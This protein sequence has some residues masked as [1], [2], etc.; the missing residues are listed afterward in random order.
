[1]GFTNVSWPFEVK[2]SGTYWKM[3]QN[4]SKS[5]LTKRNSSENI[6]KML[7]NR[8]LKRIS[9]NSYKNLQKRMKK[10]EKKGKKCF[11]LPCRHPNFRAMPNSEIRVGVFWR[12][13]FFT[14][15]DRKTPENARKREKKH[16]IFWKTTENGPQTMFWTQFYKKYREFGSFAPKF[17]YFYTTDNDIAGLTKIKGSA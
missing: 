4:F 16:K 11:L 2:P 3:K 8:I 10:I 5:P 14:Y 17:G 6:R 12:H 15:F 13:V 1:M 9:T 7:A